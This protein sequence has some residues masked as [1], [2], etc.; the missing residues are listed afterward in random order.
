[1]DDNREN[2][3]LVAIGANA[4]LATEDVE[5][6]LAPHW[7][8]LD[9]L[10]V[11][12][13]IP[14]EVVRGVVV[15]GA[16]RGIPVVVDAGP[17]RQYGPACWGRATV[18]SPNMLEA[19]E[20]V[21]YPVEDEIAAERAALDILARGPKAVVIKMGARGSFLL[22][23]KERVLTDGFAVEVVDTTGA[24]DAFTAAL[25]VGLAEGRPLREVVRL[26]NAAG[27]L[28]VT[29]FGTMAAM[30]TRAEVEHFLA[31]RTSTHYPIQ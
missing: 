1:V 16:E 27:A 15:G 18:L 17:P 24:G 10:L 31:A 5:A 6:A 2:T 29:H 19:A 8:E 25:T 11:N 20:L 12:F 21:G 4:A 7:P 28:A 22:T 9:A 14:E 23:K 3:I 26:A 13:E 30:P